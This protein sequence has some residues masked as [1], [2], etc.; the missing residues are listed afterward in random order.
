MVLASLAEVNEMPLESARCRFA[1][2][3]V[4]ARLDALGEPLRLRSGQACRRS[5][6]H[7][8][9]SL[10]AFLSTSSHTGLLNPARGGRFYASALGNVGFQVS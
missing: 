2:S 10:R 6:P 8:H 5:S 9:S 3:V 4:A 7:L 1:K